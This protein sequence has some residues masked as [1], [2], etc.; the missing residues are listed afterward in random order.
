V[1]RTAIIR[2][3]TR[4]DV[5]H[6]NILRSDRRG[7][8]AIDPKGIWGPRAYEY[9]NTLCN[10]YPHTHIVAAASRMERQAAI[11]AD[12]ASIEK[13]L[14]LRFAFLH[15]AQAASWSLGQPDHLHWLSCARTA[16]SLAALPL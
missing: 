13:N 16:A 11:I 8:L 14:L 4:G 12:R 6:F 15:A 5:H 2:L 7:W 1:S 3:C 10:P 9:A